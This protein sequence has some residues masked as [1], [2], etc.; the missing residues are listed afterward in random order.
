MSHE[1]SIAT[2]PASMYLCPCCGSAEGTRF[3]HVM[4]KALGDLWELNAEE[5]EYIDLQQGET[6]VQCGCNLR[7]QALALAITRAYGHRGPFRAF[8]RSVKGRLLRVLEINTAGSLTQHFARKSRRE[9]RNYPD[10][11]MMDMDLPDRRYDLVVHSDTLEHVPDPV[12]ALRECHR[13]LK[14]GGFCC[15]TV[16]IVVGRISR[17]C[18]G[19]PPSYHGDPADPK[20]DYLVRTEY[21]SD[22]W[23]Q[24]IEAGFAECR[25]VAVKP[26]A[27]HALVGVKAR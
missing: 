25:I 19:L 18:E 7:S 27:A 15:Y 14:P 4:W 20:D 9:L 23:R 24:V 8:A 22:A 10:L 3:H 5:F 11:D 12:R 26:P 16:P 1:D 17:S 2:I 13:V 6:C 21:G